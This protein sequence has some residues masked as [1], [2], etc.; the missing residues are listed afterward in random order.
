M[1][2]PHAV[3]FDDVLE[4]VESLPEEQQEHL[5]DIVHRRQIERR[6]E[7][8]ATSIEDARQELARGEVRRGSVDELLS[9][10]PHR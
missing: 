5:I 8:L 6:R 9:E 7:A 4:A 1:A 2:E 3:R 10:I